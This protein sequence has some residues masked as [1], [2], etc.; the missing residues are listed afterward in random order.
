MDSEQLSSKYQQK[1]D[2]EHILANPDTYIGSVEQV[3]TK[4]WILEES[5]GGGGGGSGSGS[6]KITEKTV[7]IFWESITYL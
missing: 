5:G 4:L 7:Q 2:K 6:D 3:D 1:T